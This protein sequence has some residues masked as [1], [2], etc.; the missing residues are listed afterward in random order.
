MN[1]IP[2]VNAGPDATINEGGAFTSSGNFTDTD[3]DNWTATV[4][5]GDSLSILPLTLEP[6]KIFALNHTYL[7]NGTYIVT[8]TVTDNKGGTGNDN[9]IVIVNNVAPVVNAVSDTTINEGSIFA[10]SGTFTDPGAD[11]WVATVDYGDGSGIKPLT[12]NPDKTFDLSHVYSD[13]STYTVIVSVMDDDGDVGSDA[14]LVMVKNVA[15]SVN[16]GPDW[17]IHSGDM[18]SVNATFTDTGTQ[19]TH[20]ASID[21]DDGTPPEPGVVTESGGSGNVTGTHTYLWPG[22]YTVV[23]TVIDN[24]GGA[25]SDSFVVGVIAV[26]AV[27]INSVMDDV[28]DLN[29]QEGIKNSLTSKLNIAIK[30]IQDDNERN[31]NTAVNALKAF[32]NSVNAQC[33]KKITIED[34]DALITKAEMIVAILSEE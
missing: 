4:D 27:L 23:I 33:G 31:D 3:A 16:A 26:P 19:D 22:P 34:A 20:T 32:I 11:T 24:D 8:V 13:N 15:P 12:L 30:R 29:I 21:W 2:L 9:A 6:D 7:D 14:V 18:V 1:V 17:T 5:Y 25:N 10:S 28:L